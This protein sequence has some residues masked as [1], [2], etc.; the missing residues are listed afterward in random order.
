MLYPYVQKGFYSSIYG[1]VILRRRPAGWPKATLTETKSDALFMQYLP[2]FLL[3]P[4]PLI[5]NFHPCTL[6]STNTAGQY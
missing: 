4:P 3:P 5:Y 1:N 2:F 6:I